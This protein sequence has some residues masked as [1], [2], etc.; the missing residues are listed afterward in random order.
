M[1]FVF[2]MINTSYVIIK[3]ICKSSENVGVLEL[4]S[5]RVWQ[6]FKLYNMWTSWLLLV[7]NVYKEPQNA[8]RINL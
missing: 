4:V 2:A 1:Y 5:C 8:P 3:P 6:Q 7:K